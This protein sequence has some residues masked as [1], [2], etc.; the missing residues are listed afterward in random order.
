MIHTSKE[1][2]VS[3]TFVLFFFIVVGVLVVDLPTSK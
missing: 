3:L 2:T 1:S